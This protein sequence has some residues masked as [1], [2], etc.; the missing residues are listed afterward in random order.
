MKSGTALL[1]AVSL[2]LS[3]SCD[4]FA[5]PGLLVTKMRARHSRVRGGS[6]TLQMANPKVFF[7]ISINDFE[8][9]RIVFELYAD[10]VPKTAE[11]FRALCTGEKG[12]GQSGKP[13]HYKGS[14]FHRIIPQFMCQGGDFTA[15]NGTGGESIYGRTFPDENF[16]KKHTKRGLLSMANAG[17][18]TNGSQ[19]FITTVECPWLDG[20]HTVFG[21]VVEGQA[22]VDNIEAAGSKSGRPT[23]KVVIKDCGQLS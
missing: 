15:G 6:T 22:V 23:M 3:S 16:T 5:T 14:S 18:N 11:N 2:I 9:G 4:A 7:D 21:E 1:A 8:A 10:T 12:V 20:R 19:F 17:P 13:L